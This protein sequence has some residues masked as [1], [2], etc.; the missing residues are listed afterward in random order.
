LFLVHLQPLEPSIQCQPLFVISWKNGNAS[1]AIQIL[2]DQT[3]TVIK[4]NHIPV[5]ALSSDGNQGYNRRHQEFYD[6]WCPI[7]NEFGLEKVVESMIERWASEGAT[8][9]GVDSLHFAKTFRSRLLR[10][11][12][13]LI[14]QTVSGASQ[15]KLKCIL[16]L[17]APLND[18]S[19]L[20]KMR[21][22]FRVGNISPRAHHRAPRRRRPRG[23]NSSPADDVALECS[24]PRQYFNGNMG[25]YAPILFLLASYYHARA[26]RRRENWTSWITGSIHAGEISNQNAE[27]NFSL[28]GV[29]TAIPEIALDRLGTHPYENYFG[30][31]RRVVHDMNSYN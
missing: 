29:S 14:G 24:A 27:H 2:I 6:W 21:D 1:P 31:P 16:Q 22:F 9:P 30:Y 10:Y 4:D 15:E 18:V 12:L 25:S 20:A 28:N 13:T 3:L 8:I 11:L 23:G 5:I 7:Y 17:D 26:F 19:P